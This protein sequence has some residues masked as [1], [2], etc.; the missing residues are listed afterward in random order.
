MRV[1]VMVVGVVGTALKVGAVR[2]EVGRVVEVVG[3]VRVNEAVLLAEVV[4]A[5]E[6]AAEVRAA[7][8]LGRE[9]GEAVEMAAVVRAVATMEE[10]ARAAVAMAAMA[11]AATASSKVLMVVVMVVRAVALATLG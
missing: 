6:R 3:R 9:E 1:V 7:A 8:M 10:A 4:W 11:A 2:R 5:A